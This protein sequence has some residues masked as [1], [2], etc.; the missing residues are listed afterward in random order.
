MKIM[1]LTSLFLLG[2]SSAAAHAGNKSA[3]PMTG[4]F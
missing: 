4:G 1:L 3:A 2:A